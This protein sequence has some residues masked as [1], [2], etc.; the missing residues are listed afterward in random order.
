[1]F[2]NPYLATVTI[3]AGN[4]APLGWMFCNG[5]LLSISANTALFSLIGTTYGGDGQTTFGLPDLRSRI[6]IHTGQGAGL[7]NYTLGE[8][9]GHESVT[10]LSTQLPIHSHP[11][12]SLTG[13]PG[14]SSSAGSP[15][16]PTSNVPAV[17]SG[18]N[19]YNTSGTGRMAPTTSTPNTVSSG[20][21]QP[22]S[23]LPPTLAMNYIIAVEGIFPSRN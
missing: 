1:M 18:I 9:G 5:Q 21:N 22:F 19:S 12:V 8:V 14:A 17:I 11:F 15:G 3:F 13:A 20:G 16:D 2:V 23:N 6:A 7:A 4:F 10:M